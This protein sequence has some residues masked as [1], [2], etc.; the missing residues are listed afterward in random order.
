MGT[1]LYMTITDACRIVQEYSRVYCENDILE[2]LK[3]MEECYDDL[4][5]EE[6]VAYQMFMRD[7][8]RMFAPV[9]TE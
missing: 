9:D 8:R 3:S 7:A 2:G 5:K 6:R 4:D 1:P